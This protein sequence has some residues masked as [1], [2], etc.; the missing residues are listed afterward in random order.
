MYYKEYKFQYILIEN[1]TIIFEAITLRI[2]DKEK[3]TKTKT[4]PSQKANGG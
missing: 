3:E 2:F 1:T 4:K